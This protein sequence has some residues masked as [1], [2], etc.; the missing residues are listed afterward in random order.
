M[1]I[2]KILV[3]FDVSDAATTASFTA[4]ALAEELGAELVI[5]NVDELQ[6]YRDSEKPSVLKHIE[7]ADA[8]WNE[9]LGALTARL[10]TL[11][12]KYTVARSFHEYLDEGLLAYVEDNDVDLVVMG[13]DAREGFKR[14]ML[15]SNV[16]RVLRKIHVPV[17][18][19]P[20]GGTGE[21]SHPD[22]NKI[23]ATSDFSDD[24]LR[25]LRFA[26][27]LG[28]GLKAETEVLHISK[29][30]RFQSELEFLASDDLRA[31]KADAEK[32][33]TESCKGLST[34]L[35]VAVRI[36]E[37]VANEV[38]LGAEEGGSDLIIIPTHGRGM[39]HR[40]LVGSTAQ[41]VLERSTKVPV[42]VIPK[43]AN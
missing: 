10:E 24:S 23:T 15:G 8:A 27:M 37:S 29:L 28:E 20:C 25:G 40:L 6:P 7:A 43:S 42:M 1:A 11:N 31:L 18:V 39:L 4:E 9:K 41:Q 2:Q 21:G 3:A 12:V 35:S 19:V 14:F 17:A 30:P 32:S 16:Q 33:L 36:G 5:W 38:I 22:F 13:R 34:K 26:A